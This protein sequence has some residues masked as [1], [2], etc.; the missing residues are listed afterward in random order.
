[1]LIKIN[2][3]TIFHNKQTIFNKIILE[4]L[5]NYN[6]YKKILLYKKFIS[7]LKFWQKLTIDDYAEIHYIRL[8][9]STDL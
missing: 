7:V 8:F 5:S 4:N 2:K 1:M 6:Y 3:I 9:S